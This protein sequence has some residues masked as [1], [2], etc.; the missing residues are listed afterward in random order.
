LCGEEA[1][2]EEVVVRRGKG[3]GEERKAT[4]V[5]AL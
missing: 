1:E 2:A 4:E 5:V 3:G